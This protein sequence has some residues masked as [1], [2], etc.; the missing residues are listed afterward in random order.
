MTVTD[1]APGRAPATA[2]E[3]ARV[4]SAPVADLVERMLTDSDNVLAEALAHLAGAATGNGASFAGGAAA[5]EASMGELGITL[6]D[7]RVADGSGLS[8][9]NAVPPSA[10]ASLLTLVAKGERPG[11]GPIASGLPVAGV[12]GTLA[13]RFGRGLQR[14]AAGY[15]RAKTGTLRN[16]TALAGT[17][18]DVD[19]RVLAF[20]VIA[21]GVRSVPGARRAVDRFASL[22]ADCGCR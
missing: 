7:G 22:L 20:A 4:E 14:D 17:V 8:S 9:R 1:V 16:V 13:D 15:V 21:N 19:G 6:G 5:V 18:E 12:T 11:L 10:L 2:T 3:I